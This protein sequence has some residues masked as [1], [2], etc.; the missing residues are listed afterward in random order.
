[1]AAGPDDPRHPP[2]T[3]RRRFGNKVHARPR[4][5]DRQRSLRLRQCRRE[6]RRRARGAAGAAADRQPDRA[7]LRRRTSALLRSAER[8]EDSI[9]V[10]T[11]FSRSG[12]LN[13]ALTLLRVVVCGGGCDSFVSVV[14]VVSVDVVVCVG[15]GVA[16][17]VGGVC[18]SSGGGGAFF[19]GVGGVSTSSSKR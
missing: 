18:T 15:A 19:F 11:G 13:P 5:T 6:S 16:V 2:G 7:Q 10:R 1:P 3:C 9:S 14:S 8:R 17:S 12:R 4:R